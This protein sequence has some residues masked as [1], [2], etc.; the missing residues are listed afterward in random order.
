[1]KSIGLWISVVL[2]AAS[3]AL[4][5]IKPGTWVAEQ[6]AQDQKKYA[7]QEH[8]LVKPGLVADRKNKTV[9]VYGETTGLA[10]DEICEYLLI[11]A[12]AGKEY[13]SAAVQF[14]KASD[15]LEAMKFIGMK[16]G[17]CADYNTL[18]FWP[19][20]DRVI[21]TC[22]WEAGG[23]TQQLRLEELAYNK[24]TNES[25]K[26]T[27]FMFTGSY[28]F[29]NSED[30]QVLAA[31]VSDSRSLV[32]TFNDP[33]TVF[34]VPNQ[35]PQGAVYEQFGSH[36]DNP[37][38]GLVKGTHLKV[39]IKP[40]GKNRLIDLDWQAFAGSPPTYK[41]LGPEGK[42]LLSEPTLAAVL[43]KF[44]ELNKQGKDVY[45]TFTPG[46]KIDLRSVRAIAQVLAGMDSNAGI[47]VDPP[48]PGY[49]YYR[50]FLPSPRWRDREKRRFH[51]WE[52]HLKPAA[53]GTLDI[54]LLSTDDKKSDE[55]KWIIVETP[56]EVTDGKSIA[57]V[58]N[59][60]D[61][62]R[63]REIF[64][65]APNSLPHGKLIKLLGPALETHK[66][67]HVFLD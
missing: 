13:E 42:G 27:A 23:N 36:P 24:Q 52:M 3:S 10:T 16:P 2:F 14:A 1:M 44:D 39:I 22:Q 34:D 15:V 46:D 54:K 37:D 40:E 11:E 32:P 21:I 58:L 56:H 50:A 29:T 64:V 31:D 51:G 8:I 38:R 47:R 18:Q 20:G 33:G 60:V 55:G 48:K 43:A 62:R 26:K 65:F 30:K 4:A 63:P 59:K 53:D 17:K 25:M 49:L 6:T 57:E 19:K 61:T 45:V 5:E 7:G 66:T 12:G 9:T 41:L 67:I 28:W 35:A